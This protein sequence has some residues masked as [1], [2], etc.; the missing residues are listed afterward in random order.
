MRFR[1]RLNLLLGVTGAAVVIGLAGV[2]TVAGL[3]EYRDARTWFFFLPVIPGVVGLACTIWAGKYR[4][5]GDSVAVR[6]AATITTVMA[7]ITGCASAVAL[8]VLLLVVLFFSAICISGV[9]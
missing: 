3:V 6:F 8:A 5:G 1:N 4:C 9:Q 7:W 2:A